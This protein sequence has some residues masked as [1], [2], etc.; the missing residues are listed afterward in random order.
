MKQSSIETLERIAKKLDRV[1]TERSRNQARELRNVIKI[2]TKSN[3]NSEG[4][5]KC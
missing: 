2:E 3:E 5:S 4:A 1:N